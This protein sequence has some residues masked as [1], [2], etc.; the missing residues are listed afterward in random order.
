[1]G[2]VS[3]SLASHLPE[4]VSWNSR[5]G[6][7]GTGW[8]AAQGPWGLHTTL[9]GSLLRHV[10]NMKRCQKLS[11]RSFCA[12][13]SDARGLRLAP[14]T[15]GAEL[16]FPSCV[17]LIFRLC[18]PPTMRRSNVSLGREL[19]ALYTFLRQT[20]LIQAAPSD[21]WNLNLASSCRKRLPSI[22][23]QQWLK[24]QST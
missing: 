4:N 15:E 20:K 9:A 24:Q 5:V 19:F 18:A 12:V 10:N 21:S 16:S 14:G 3:A 6:P 23:N 13:C 2:V 17:A 22:P 11:G 8:R 7:T 1:M